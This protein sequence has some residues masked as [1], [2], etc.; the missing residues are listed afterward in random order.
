M[1]PRWHR[2]TTW[3]ALL[4]LLAAPGPASARPGPQTEPLPSPSMVE[5]GGILNRGQHAVV[6]YLD[7]ELLLPPI[8]AG[9]RYGV[10]SW[11]ELGLDVGANEGL[12]QGLLHAR[13][14]L[15]ESPRSRRLFVGLRVRTGPKYHLL[16]LSQKI[17]FDDRSWVVAG[18]LSL[19]VRLGDRRQLA[20]YLSPMFYADVDLRTPQRQT[21]LYLAP[22]TVGFELLL[23]QG[24]SVF[25]EIGPVWGINGTETHRGKLYEGDWFPVGQLG[26]AVRFP[27]G[28]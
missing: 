8:T 5:N 10:L 4:G 12:I 20:L 2:T 1:N 16:E 3:L 11:L 17:L 25:G 21:D 24:A 22:A 28:D 19:A 13:A 27:P 15:Y 7:A 23:G 18:E 14:R 26:V 9:Y 6:L